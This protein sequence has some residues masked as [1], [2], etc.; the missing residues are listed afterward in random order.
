MQALQVPQRGWIAAGR[1]VDSLVLCVLWRP[2]MP[3][4]L[5]ASSESS[6]YHPF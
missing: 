5:K 3:A 4:Y 6:E 2:E 1:S